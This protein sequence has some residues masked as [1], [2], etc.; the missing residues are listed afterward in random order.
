[1]CFV[2]LSLLVK[3]VLNIVGILQTN[4]FGTLSCWLETIALLASFIFVYEQDF[5]MNITLRCPFQWEF[6]TFGL[7]LIWL[8]LLSCIQFIPMIGIYAT[9][10]FCNYEEIYS[11][12]F[13]FTHPY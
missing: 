9:M 13:C 4:F 8:T 6:G 2:I 10:L 11:I 3:N 1:M 5:Q 12:F 7:L